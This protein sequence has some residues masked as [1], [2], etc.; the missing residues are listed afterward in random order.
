MHLPACC[1]RSHL[2]SLSF[3]Q[4]CLAWSVIDVSRRQVVKG[5]DLH[6]PK[7]S[8]GRD[9]VIHLARFIRV[10]GMDS[11]SPAV[12]RNGGRVSSRSVLVETCLCPEPASVLPKKRSQHDFIRSVLGVAFSGP[13]PC[14][15]GKLGW[16]RQR[17]VEAN[18]QLQ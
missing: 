4:H 9:A 10:S 11:L 5:G 8:S 17:L 6:F 1:Y 2:D 3:V 13:V 14:G 15:Q 12:E 18:L 7:G 16:A